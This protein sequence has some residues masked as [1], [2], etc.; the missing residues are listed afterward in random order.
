MAVFAY[1]HL[2]MRQLVYTL[3]TGKIEHQEKMAK[4]Q[5][6]GN[7]ESPE[8]FTQRDM[9]ILVKTYNHTIDA[10]RFITNYTEHSNKATF[11]R[12]L[13]RHEIDDLTYYTHFPQNK[14]ISTLG[15]VNDRHNRSQSGPYDPFSSFLSVKIRN[16][17]NEYESAYA[18]L[19]VRLGKLHWA[20]QREIVFAF[21]KLCG[22]VNKFKSKYKH[23][24]GLHKK[25]ATL[26]NNI[27]KIAQIIGAPEN[28]WFNG[29]LTLQQAIAVCDK[30][31]QMSR[32]IYPLHLYRDILRF[33]AVQ[34]ATMNV[35]REHSRKSH[36]N[37]MQLELESMSDK[38]IEL[39]QT[40]TELSKSVSQLTQQN[41]E[42]TTQN[43][44]MAQQLA[45]LQR[46]LLGKIA[47]KL[48]Q[49]KK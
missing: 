29:S 17:I 1:H 6:S 24:T 33:Q 2:T 45:T 46:S 36:Y 7:A 9:D 27:N 48:A 3:A 18:E 44:Q 15:M 14:L 13:R 39:A 30:L 26:D 35:K 38:N 21:D 12:S 23:V 41:Y 31:S 19:G 16:E 10:I 4:I 37:H 40:N 47:I 43:Q 34:E 11:E 5:Y 49:R 32:P 20:F 28:K 42:L 22:A 25:I 8:S